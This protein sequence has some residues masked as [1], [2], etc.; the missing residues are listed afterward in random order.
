[1]GKMPHIRLDSTI[2]ADAAILPGDPA[3]V[4]A[5]AAHMK[6]VREEAF[7]REYRSVTGTYRGKRIIVMSTGMGG[8]STAIGL[9]ELAD[10]GVRKVIRIGSC[11]ALQSS[12]RLGDL[13]ICERAV[14]DDGASQ[15][16][17]GSLRYAAQ[18]LNGDRSRE[19][20]EEA[21]FI[22]FA[23]ADADLAESCR[24][25]AQRLGY[26]HTV[27]S[28]RCHDRLYSDGKVDLDA[29]YS[30]KGITASDMETAALLAAAACRGVQ[31]CSILNVVVEWQADLREGVS[32]YNE[33]AK[34]AALGEEREI[35]TAL[36]ALASC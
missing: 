27:G 31:A 4:L 12:L 36:E 34:A 26:P 1:M 11:G 7:N 35:L 16:Y 33:G 10:I 15:T 8:A 30:A 18:E 17:M 21:G 9:E 25:A 24:Q 5:A 2:G 6:D 20:E 29:F 19:E 22:R 28:T 32:S 23:S 14:C 13:V 3:R